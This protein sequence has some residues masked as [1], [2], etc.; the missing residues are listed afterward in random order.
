MPVASVAVRMIDSDLKRLDI[1]SGW[2]FDGTGK[3]RHVPVV[4]F[5]R[6]SVGCHRFAPC[7]YSF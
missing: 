2:Q 6:H 7:I 5:Q 4:S 1:N 3:E